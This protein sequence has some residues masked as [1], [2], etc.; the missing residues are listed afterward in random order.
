M[1]PIVLSEVLL[2]G[3]LALPVRPDSKIPLT[4]DSP[5]VQQA[6]RSFIPGAQWMEARIDSDDEWGPPMRLT[7]SEPVTKATLSSQKEAGSSM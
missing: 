2:L 6:L 1:T 3:L 4:Y 7:T 5:K